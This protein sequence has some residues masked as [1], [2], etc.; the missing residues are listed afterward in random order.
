MTPL[1]DLP[2]ASTTLASVGAASS[3]MFDVLL[4]LGLFAVGFIVG[5][6]IVAFI[7][8]AITGALSRVMH[9]PER[10]D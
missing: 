2:A 6:L 4:P 9:R 3:P 1:V 7:I 5:G 10:F 8:D